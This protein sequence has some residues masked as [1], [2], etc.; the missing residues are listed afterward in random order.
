MRADALAHDSINFMSCDA[1]LA[2]EFI[3]ITD[4]L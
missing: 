1:G 4:R 3:N 2:I